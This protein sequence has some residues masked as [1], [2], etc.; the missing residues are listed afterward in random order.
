M[1]P[2]VASYEGSWG[3]APARAPF[4]GVARSPRLARGTRLPGVTSWLS[5][6]LNVW[7]DEMYSL[8]SSSGTPGFAFRQALHFELQPPLYFVLLSLWRGIDSSVF[9]ARLFLRSSGAVPFC[10]SAALGERLLPKVAPVWIAA[11]VATHPVLVWAGTE[12]RVYALIL[13]LSALLTLAFFDAHWASGRRGTQR[14][15]SCRSRPA[16]RVHAVLPGRSFGLLWHRAARPARPAKRGAVCRDMG[17]VALLAFPLVVAARMQFGSIRKTLGPPSPFGVG[18]LAPRRDQARRYIFSFNKAIDEAR[19]SLGAIRIA[20]WMYRAMV[21]A[22]IAFPC[23]RC[24]GVPRGRAS[25]DGGRC[26]SSWPATRCACSL[27]FAWRDRSAWESDTPS[28]SSF[29]RSSRPCRCLLLRWGV[30][31]RSS[32][33]R[34]SSSRTSPRRS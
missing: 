31:Q 1:K 24:D 34:F 9:F 6:E 7:R 16:L 8:H 27:C 12:I 26:S 29:R 21:L 23:G 17:V 19:W 30:W 33:Q 25:S 20:R 10:A 2:V 32:G 11:V 28:R 22:V 15:L 4:G 5:L 14:I 3:T 18:H 13:L